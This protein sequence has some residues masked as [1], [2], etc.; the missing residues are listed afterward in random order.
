MFVHVKHDVEQFFSKFL[1]EDDMNFFLNTLYLNI[2]KKIKILEMY[3]NVQNLSYMQKD[4]TKEWSSSYY[5]L[6]GKTDI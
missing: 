6:K 3:K 4:S 1:W 2:S 5:Y